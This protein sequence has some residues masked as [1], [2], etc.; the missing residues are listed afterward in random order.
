MTVE[1]YKTKYTEI[2]KEAEQLYKES[3]PI[4]QKL[5]KFS[6]KCFKLGLK[7][8]SDKHLYTKDEFSHH[9]SIPDNW[10]IH[11]LFRLNE[12]ECGIQDAEELM[13]LLYNIMDTTFKP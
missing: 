6:K 7:V 3:K 2:Q 8:D 5:K 10:N 13:A 9:E 1:E 11:I 12:F 4:L